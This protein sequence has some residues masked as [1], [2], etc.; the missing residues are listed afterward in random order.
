MLMI[1]KSCI[2]Q[3][4]YKEHVYDMIYKKIAQIFHYAFQ[5]SEAVIIS[6]FSW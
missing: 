4:Y 2:P 6:F 5:E 1:L 3:T